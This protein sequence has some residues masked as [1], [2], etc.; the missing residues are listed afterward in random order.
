[1]VGTRTFYYDS[2]KQKS[3]KPLHRDDCLALIPL[4]DCFNH[5]NGGCD[6]TFSPSGYQIRTDRKIDKGEEIFIS[7]G[8]HGND[9]LLTEY[10]FI[11]DHN[12]WD[13]MSLDAVIL[14]LFSEEQR[15]TLKREGFL[16]KY[17]LDKRT[18]C[19]RTQVAL[20]LLCMSPKYWQ[21]LVAN[22]FEDEDKFQSAINQILLEALNSYL[23][24]AH[25]RLKQVKVLDCGLLQQRNTLSRRWD[26]L[27][28]LLTTA[29]SRIE[30]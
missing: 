10:G 22:G 3:K 12:E 19:Y 30:N 11:M 21:R 7:Y 29:I 15:Q 8:N 17:V 9:F 23:S 18:A 1:L 14:P 16:G 25:E 20:K 13:E 24:I 26:Q 6:V 5:T 28:L 27:S 2:P 4:A